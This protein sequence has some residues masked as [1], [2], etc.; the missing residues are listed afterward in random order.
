VSGGRATAGLAQGEVDAAA[1]AGVRNSQPEGIG[2]VVALDG[3]LCWNNLGRNV[4]FANLEAH[5]YTV[6]GT[7]M[8]PDQD[9]PS[10]YDLDI[11]AI[12][13]LPEL[14]MVGVLNHLGLFRAFRRADV[15]E[16]AGEGLV[17]PACQWWFVADVE[18]SVSAAGQLVASAPRSDGGVGLLV[19]APLSSLPPSG[20]IPVTLSATAFGEVTALGVVP[21]PQG[22]SI[23]VGGDGKATLLA[24]HKGQLG[25]PKW[26]ADVA[27][28]VAS[29]ACHHG[30]LWVAG[31]DRAAVDDYDWEQLKGG[32]YA[33]L[34]LADGREVASGP[35][36]DDIAW[37]TGGAA[38]APFSGF[39]VAA[40]R[41][42]CLYLVDPGAD[43]KWWSTAPLARTSLGI[44]HMAVVS[45]R[46]FCGFNRGGYRLFSFA[47]APPDGAAP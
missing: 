29:V 44:A 43:A 16:P 41:T 26:V 18:R 19:S 15:Q 17:E 33:A 39:L 7:T 2:R 27:F 6:F 28:R 42:G 32:G 11:H 37:G 45:D 22:P 31:P 47:Q 5:P 1:R 34:D 46:V 8:F 38:V 9:E 20:N 14:G 10:Q 4:V 23:A 30:A 3:L 21:P 25:A 36:P 12:V 24:F 35:L 40:G 13:D